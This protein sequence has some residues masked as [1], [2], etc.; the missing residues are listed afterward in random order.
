MTYADIINRKKK[1]WNAPD[2][3]DS[4]GKDASDKIPF[5]SCLMNWSTYGGIPRGR[6][7]EFFG[8]P[9]A[10]KSTSSVDICKNEVQLIKREFEEKKEVLSTQV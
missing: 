2:M 5:S 10:G 1:E 6:I 4:A 8:E 3:M 9:G 7:S